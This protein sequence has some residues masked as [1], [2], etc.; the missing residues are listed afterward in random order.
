MQP[1]LDTHVNEGQVEWPPSPWRILRALVAS[2]FTTQHWKTIPES[3][4]CLIE[5]LAAVVPSYVLPTATG[6]R[7]ADILPI[8]V[9]DKG[10]EK[11]TLVYDTWLDIGDS[12]LEVNW[13]CELTRPETEQAASSLAESLGYLG[14]SESWVEVKLVE[15]SVFSPNRPEMQSRM[16][17]N[18]LAARVGSRFR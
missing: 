7:T 2:G 1:R 3:A 14:R 8:G 16:G 13:H 17:R 5:K 18:P 4:V 10:R 11:T 12:T 6:P 9:F 15:D